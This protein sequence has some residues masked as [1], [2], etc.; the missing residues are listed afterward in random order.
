MNVDDNISREELSESLENLG[1]C[2]LEETLQAMIGMIDAHGDD[3]K[4]RIE[5]KCPSRL[6]LWNSSAPTL[7][8]GAL[9]W[10]TEKAGKVIAL[11]L[12]TEKF[13]KLPLPYNCNPSEKI[14]VILR[15]ID[16]PFLCTLWPSSDDK[17]NVRYYSFTITIFSAYAVVMADEGG[18]EGDDIEEE[19]REAFR[20]LDRDGASSSRWMS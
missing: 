9:H 1:V 11:H 5:E 19:V 7:L 18:N 16:I 20:V 8:N 15:K 6:C 14:Q 4:V 12:G 13:R 17:L 3:Y 2:V 10:F